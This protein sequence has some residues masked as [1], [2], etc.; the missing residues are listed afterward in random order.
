MFAAFRLRKQA[1]RS[2]YPRIV[3]SASVFLVMFRADVIATI[4]LRFA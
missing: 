3:Q 1:S 2:V 4:C